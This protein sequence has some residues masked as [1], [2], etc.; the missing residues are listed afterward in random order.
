MIATC[1]TCLICMIFIWKLYEPLYPHKTCGIQLF[2]IAFQLRDGSPKKIKDNS[3][4]QKFGRTIRTEITCVTKMKEMHM[5]QWRSEHNY[6]EKE[7]NLS[8]IVF[9]YN[10]LHYR[11][12]GHS[13][14]GSRKLWTMP[15]FLL[16]VKGIF[17]PL[18]MLHYGNPCI[19][20]KE[21]CGCMWFNKKTYHFVQ[22]PF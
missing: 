10:D 2:S 14:T 1:I 12:K 8:S 20:K 7:W 22:Y 17:Q 21:H 15:H 9:C 13:N 18:S 5:W 16:L 6:L 19:S 4:F 3:G 11:P